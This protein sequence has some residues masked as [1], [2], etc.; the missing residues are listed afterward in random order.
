V[1]ASLNKK[2]VAL[3]GGAYATREPDQ[4]FFYLKYLIMYNLYCLLKDGKPIY[5]G[6]TKNIINRK[7][8]HKK[9]KDFDQFIVI[10]KYKDKHLA[11]C[12]ENSLIRFNG[13]FDI[14][15]KNAKYANDDFINT[16]YIKREVS[17]G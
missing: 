17:N 1:V 12:A 14:G 3:I 16:F 5:V 10:K 6:V 15:L 13:L 9:T 11:Y 7:S 2:L 8:K 4:G